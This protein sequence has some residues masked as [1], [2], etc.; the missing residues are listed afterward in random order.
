MF[1]FFWIVALSGAREM[2]VV[3]PITL[4]VFL[5]LIIRLMSHDASDEHTVCRFDSCN[6]V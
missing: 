6:W 3:L 4:Q 5:P 2:L 1:Y